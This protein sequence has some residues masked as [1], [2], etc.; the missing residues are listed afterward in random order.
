MQEQIKTIKIELAELQGT[1]D[2]KLDLVLQM[3]EQILKRG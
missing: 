3:V 2:S 1:R